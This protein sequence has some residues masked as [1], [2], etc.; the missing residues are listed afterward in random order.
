MRYQWP[1][2]N[3]AKLERLSVNS[4][5]DVTTVFQ[6]FTPKTSVLYRATR[7]EE[8]L[9]NFGIQFLRAILKKR[10]LIKVFD[11]EIMGEM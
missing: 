1:A 6:V 3:F 2:V 4:N 9:Y 5:I 11:I 8:R 10:I 7:E